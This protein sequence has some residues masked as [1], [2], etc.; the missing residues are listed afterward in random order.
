MTTVVNISKALNHYLVSELV[1][2]DKEYTL[3]VID[4]NEWIIE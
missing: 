4:F 3:V 2:G 1:E